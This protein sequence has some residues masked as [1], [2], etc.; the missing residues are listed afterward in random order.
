MIAHTAITILFRSLKVFAAY[1]PHPDAVLHPR[2]GL[3]E[4]A[5]IHGVK[6]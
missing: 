2:I 4:C 5:C 3:P 6:W 1:L